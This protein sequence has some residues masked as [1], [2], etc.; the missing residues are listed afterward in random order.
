MM[1]KGVYLFILVAFVFLLL[2]CSSQTG[3]GLVGEKERI[4]SNILSEYYLI[5]EAYLENKKYP[6]AIEYY[7]KALSHPDLSESARYKIAYSYALSEN[8]EKAKSCYEELLA[9]DPDNSE[10]EKSL[11]YVYARQGDLAHASAMYRRLVEKNPY[12]QSLLENFI[13]VLIAGNYLE[14][15]ELALQQLTEN[16][17]DNTVAEKFEEKLSKAWE[18]QEGKNLSSEETQDEVIPSDEKTTIAENAAM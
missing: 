17:H 5:G 16:F 8:W 1:K 9:K 6:K 7:T 2:G 14:E 13:T 15:A 3:F 18:S 10:L 11:A 4:Y 12:D